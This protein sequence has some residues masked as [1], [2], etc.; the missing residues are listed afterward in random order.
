MLPIS[1]RATPVQQTQKPIQ[2]SDNGQKVLSKTNGVYNVT[3]QIMMAN[4]IS[5]EKD[6]SKRVKQAGKLLKDSVVMDVYTNPIIGTDYVINEY[7]KGNITKDEAKQIITQNAI[8][9]LNSL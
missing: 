2:L 3:N 9:V 6:F 7:K 4:E 1:F 8:T 5:K